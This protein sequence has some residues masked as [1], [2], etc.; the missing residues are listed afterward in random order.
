M[1]AAAPHQRRLIRVERVPGA[2][3]LVRPDVGGAARGAPPVASPDG[4]DV[5][6]RDRV[7][8][9]VAHLVGAGAAPAVRARGVRRRALEHALHDGLQERE[10]GADHGGLA[11]DDR[12]DP[13]DRDV[14]AAGAEAEQEDQTD[15]ADNGDTAKM[16]V[17]LP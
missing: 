5:R 3:L 10:A 17:S 14:V 2:P 16:P 7:Q 6:V 8:V 12:Q 9:R 1:L 13:W 15:A 11:L 4:D